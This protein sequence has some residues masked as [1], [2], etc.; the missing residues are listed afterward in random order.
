MEFSTKV[1]EKMAAIVAEEIGQLL[2]EPK[3][4]REV[5]VGMRE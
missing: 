2:P 3:D 5:E 4:I 1:I